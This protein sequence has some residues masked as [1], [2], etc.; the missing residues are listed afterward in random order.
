MARRLHR[1]TLALGS[2][3]THSLNTR[4]LRLAL[5]GDV[6]EPLQ[7][8]FEDVLTDG[9]VRYEV[10]SEPDGCDVVIVMVNWGDDVRAITDACALAGDVPLLA[11][12]PFGDDVLAQRVLL[13]GAQGWFALDTSLALLRAELVELANLGSPTD[14]VVA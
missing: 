3:L 12:L 10:S 6:T 5:V 1:L 11:I 13:A 14:D 2:R 9:G 4:V 8:L 7:H